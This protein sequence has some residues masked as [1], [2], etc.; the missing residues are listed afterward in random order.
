MA[1][2]V[3]QVQAGVCPECGHPLTDP[4]KSEV[5]WAW[6]RNPQ[7]RKPWKVEVFGLRRLWA[8]S[9][10]KF[11]IESVKRRINEGYEK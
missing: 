5:G 11:E 2:R 10:S 9:P 6:C 8:S 4:A 3:E 7:C 1:R